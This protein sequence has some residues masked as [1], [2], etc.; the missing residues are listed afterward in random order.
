MA[1]LTP[2][3]KAELEAK[4]NT[5]IN[6]I[7]KSLEKLKETL[8]KSQEPKPE[9]KMDAQRI[10]HEIRT[11]QPTDAEINFLLSQQVNQSQEGQAEAEARA[12]EERYRRMCEEE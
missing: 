11:R 4:Y 5:K 9:P 6:T 1:D 7:K 2:E 12:A 10:M 3:E 8:L